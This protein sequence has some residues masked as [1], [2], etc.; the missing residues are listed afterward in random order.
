M[1]FLDGIKEKAKDF[2]E[3]TIN[4]M[5]KINEPKKKKENKEMNFKNKFKS[6]SKKEES[7]KEIITNT[8][9]DY[10]NTNNDYDTDEEDSKLKYEDNDDSTEYEDNDNSIEYEDTAFDI[11]FSKEYIDGILPS[12]SN[13][14]TLEEKQIHYK[15]V[16]KFLNIPETYEIE[17]GILFPDDIDKYSFDYQAPQGYETSQVDIFVEI[18][19]KSIEKYVNL[20]KERNR[21]IASLATV[22]DRLQVDNQN[23]KYQS[24]IADGISIM[25]TSS[26]D[27]LELENKNLKLLLR[28]YE[29]GDIEVKKKRFDPEKDELRNRVSILEREKISLVEKLE[30]AENSLSYYLENDEKDALDSFITSNNKDNSYQDDTN[31][32]EEDALPPL[33]QYDDDE[34]PEVKN[35]PDI[36]YRS[37]RQRTQYSSSSFLSTENVD[38]LF[39]NIDSSYIAEEYN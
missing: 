9:N 25:P 14:L 39:D 26:N 19:K 20:L 10:T 23:L 12:L 16:L 38:E 31:N 1:G 32:I 2:G 8:N 27:E 30:E 17:Q 21:H 37:K 29:A 36:D 5:D 18:T 28:Q 4:I 35:T 7:N 11:S 33:S 24:E 22:V 13:E 3:E 15:D 34:L 6:L